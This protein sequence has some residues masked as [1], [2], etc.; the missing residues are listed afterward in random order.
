MIKAAAAKNR[1]PPRAERDPIRCCWRREAALCRSPACIEE[2]VMLPKL[3]TLAIAAALAVGTSGVAMAQYACPQGY[4]YYNGTCQP[5]PA[6]APAYPSAYPPAYPSGPL[7]GAAAGEANGAANGAA[8][9]GPVGAIV[10]G[11]LGTATGAVAG[12][13]NA[14]A[15]GP[16][17][18][19][20]TCAAGYTYYNG[21]CYPQLYNR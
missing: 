20:P 9:A 14:L 21:G 19:P 18:P 10:G 11:A 13:A 17:T 15:G 8:A 5:A 1:L 3:N 2:I 12:T 6:P 16:P 7:S 4:T